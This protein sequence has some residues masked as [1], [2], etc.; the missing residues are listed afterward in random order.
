M[1]T[2]QESFHKVFTLQP[3]HCACLQLGPLYLAP[4]TFLIA[5][6]CAAAVNRVLTECCAK[7]LK[8]LHCNRVDYC[9]RVACL[10]PQ[11]CMPSS[12]T[13]THHPQAFSR[14][15]SAVWRRSSRSSA[16]ESCPGS[17]SGTR[18]GARLATVGKA[19]CRLRPCVAAAR[20]SGVSNGVIAESISVLCPAHY[21]SVKGI[22][23]CLQ[24]NALTCLL[25]ASAQCTLSGLSP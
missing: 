13:R 5:S 15:L 19:V 21:G 16:W 11:L 6:V 10:V 25:C 7:L 17:G 24:D 4:C 22:C 8:T 18:C 1:H 2:T 23:A 20:L 12:R 14:Y 3:G 9:E